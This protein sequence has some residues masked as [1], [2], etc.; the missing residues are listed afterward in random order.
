[1]HKMVTI[2]AHQLEDVTF[3]ER[4]RE[5]RIRLLFHLALTSRRMIE[6]RL[7]T[8]EYLLSW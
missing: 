8:G 1:M 5:A 4:L 6:Q 3:L 7:I 2:G